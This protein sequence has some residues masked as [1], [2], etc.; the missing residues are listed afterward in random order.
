MKQLSPAFSDHVNSEVTTLATCW[1]LRRMDGFTLGFTDHDRA[2]DLLGVTCAPETGL[3]G[4][5]IRQTSG[6]AS[7]DQDISGILQ[8][9]MISEADLS[10]GRYDGATIE[11]FRVNWQQPEQHVSLR[12]GYLGKVRSDEQGF[13]AEIRG[14]SVAMEQERG[15]VYQYEC[16]ATLG[17]GRCGVD[18]GGLGLSFQGSIDDRENANIL[19]LA[20]SPRPSAG[21]LA[22]GSLSLRSGVA[23]QMSFDILSH[24]PSGEFERVELWLPLHEGVVNGDLVSATVGCN[25]SFRTCRDLFSNQMNFRGFPHIPGNDFILSY[26]EQNV[27]RDGSVLID[28][29]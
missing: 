9:D 28:E 13:Q 11:T 16:D 6:F 20:L 12:T 27:T 14:L 1:I 23:D 7:D 25:K 10:G 15:R 17:D 3:I 4:S 21:A 22:M 29:V 8:S 18:L 19:L 24:E 5:E 26:P 2:I